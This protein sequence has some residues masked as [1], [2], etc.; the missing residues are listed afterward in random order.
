MYDEMRHLV[1]IV[2]HGTFRAAAER[3][4]LSQPALSASIQR[5][6]QQVGARLLHRRRGGSRVELTEAGRVWLPWAQRALGAVQA[7][8]DAVQEVLGL[9]GGQVRLAAGATACTY[10]LPELLATYRQRYPSVSL[11]LEERRTAAVVARVA[12][13]AVDLGVITAVPAAGA[14]GLVQERWLR[15][16][17]ILIGPPGV[18]PGLAGA[19]PFVTFGPGS[20]TRDLLDRTLVGV[21]VVMELDNIAA[22]KAHVQ[23]GVGRSLVSRWAVARELAAGR[24][25]ELPHPATPV[26]RDLAL[27]HAGP[28]RLSPAAAAMRDLLLS[29][30]G[31]R[32]ALV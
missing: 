2:E 3:A 6:E 20:P 21:E 9:R 17:L 11:R 25:V 7:G 12:A 8:R 13:H 29:A 16:E 10:L 4:C 26:S 14:H 18:A 22:V 19:M 1:L 24:L 30:G 28:E 32:G 27:V 5:L 31:P 23:A 15:D